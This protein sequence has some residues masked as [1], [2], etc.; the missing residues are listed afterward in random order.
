MSWP[1]LTR[2]AQR[3]TAKSAVAGSHGELKETVG[4]VAARLRSNS[5]DVADECSDDDNAR[6][7]RFCLGSGE[8]SEVGPLLAPCGCTGTHEW[9]HARCLQTWIRTNEWN[10]GN[11]TICEL[12]RQPYKV[13]SKFLP[14][15]WV[16]LGRLKGWWKFIL[17][18]ALVGGFML[19]RSWSGESMALFFLSLCIG[20]V[21]V[22]PPFRRDADFACAFLFLTLAMLASYAIEMHAG[23]FWMASGDAIEALRPGIVLCF[24]G[25]RGSG[26]PFSRSVVLITDYSY[27]HGAAGYI[28]NKPIWS[29]AA[30]DSAMRFRSA[31]AAL[32]TAEPVEN[33]TALEFGYGG[34]VPMMRGGGWELLL[35]GEVAGD[36]NGTKPAGIG[37]VTVGGVRA[38]II[39][40]LSQQQEQADRL[41][42]D[43]DTRESLR[44]L[45][46]RGYAGWAPSQLDGEV[47]RGSWTLHNVSAQV[48]SSA[49]GDDLWHLIRALPQERASP[50]RDDQVMMTISDFNT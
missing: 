19:A 9:V 6:Q 12:C 38:E 10:G 8:D 28:V 24:N 18:V 43:A 35:I 48:L 50:E 47:R 33:W 31:A 34:P 5:S 2:A 49:K 15:Y 46:L 30:T 41:D 13:S 16:Q 20:G 32:Q 45:A 44:A 39:A 40:A 37:G 25:P 29:N 3:L 1:M 7:C 17:T 26:G 21:M 11:S 22:A 23:P 14:R 42:A 27:S 36:I 4:D